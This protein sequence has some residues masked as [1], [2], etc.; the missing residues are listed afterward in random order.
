VEFETIKLEIDGVDTVI[1]A[2][3]GGPAIFALHGAATIEGHEW[4]RRLANRFRVYL[5]FHPGCGESGSARHICGMQD[6]V[7]HNL[8]LVAALGLI[9]HTSLAIPW[10][11]GWRRKWRLSPANVLL[12]WC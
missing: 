12:A 8:R 6:L 9:G 4:A 7:V 1:K 3:G 10:V 5:P 2:I 11:A